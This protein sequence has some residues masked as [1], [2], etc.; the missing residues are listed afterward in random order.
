MVEF[1]RAKTERGEDLFIC[2]FIVE[3]IMYDFKAHIM[4]GKTFGMGNKRC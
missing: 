1:Q 2:H 4:N 3:S